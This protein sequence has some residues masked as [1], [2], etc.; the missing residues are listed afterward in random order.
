M[1]PV[2]AVSGVIVPMVTPFTVDGKV[3]IQATVRLVD[4]IVGNNAS[5]FVLGTTGESASIPGEQKQILVRAMIE[6]NAGRTLTFAG[7]S[8]NSF[9][10]SVN[11]AKLYFEEG[12]DVFVAHPPCYYSISDNQMLKYFEKLADSIPGPLIL[13]NIPAV[14]HC[15]ISLQTIDSL[16]NHPNI[17][18]I[19][20]SERDFERLKTIL[21]NLRDTPDFVHLVGWGAQMAYGLLNGSKG[22]VPSSGN[23]VPQ[24]YVQLYQAVQKREDS[25]IEQL[26]EE[27]DQISRIYQEGRTLGKSLAA[28]KV[29]LSELGLCDVYLLPPLDRL[30]SEEEKSIL[31]QMREFQVFVN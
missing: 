13:Y 23:L 12:V 24:L 10:A 21:D 3:D 22:I 19:K 28:L 17:F 26:R 6:A 20:D 8:S 16:M 4:H 31:R 2:A 27:L 5:P 14:T 9:T 30:D 25:K 18:G 15:S 11:E 29:M 7:I 1:D